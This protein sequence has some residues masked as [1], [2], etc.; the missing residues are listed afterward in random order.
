MISFLF[1]ASY[2]TIIKWRYVYFFSA[3][4]LRSFGKLINNS[5]SLNK[6]SHDLDSVLISGLKI[7]TIFFLSFRLRLSF[8]WE[9]I[10]NTQDRAGLNTFPITSKFIQNTPLRA[11]LSSRCL[12]VW[13]NTVF[14]V[15]CFISCVQ[16]ALLYRY[17]DICKRT[18]LRSSLRRLNFDWQ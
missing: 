5:S 7:F 6:G 12:E 8:N 1:F 11:K 13:S 17:R 14:C 10:S 4:Q 15:W 2:C 16:K 9:D 3:L 18:F